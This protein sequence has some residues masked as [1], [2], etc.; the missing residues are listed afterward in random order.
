LIRFELNTKQK[1]S[2]WLGIIFILVMGIVPPW[3]YTVDAADH[4]HSEKPAGYHLIT[5]PPE[6]EMM[7]IHFGVSIDFSRLF[8][9]WATVLMIIGGLLLVFKGPPP[10]GKGRLVDRATTTEE[11][12][13]MMVG[14]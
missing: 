7:D 1:L 14:R 10:P 12:Y 9:Q 11:W 8:I 4:F 5:H 3:I 13:D 2:L 6:P